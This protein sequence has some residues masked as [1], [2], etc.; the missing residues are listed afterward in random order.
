MIHS[1]YILGNF[2]HIEIVFDCIG[3]PGSPPAF[4]DDRYAKLAKL[5]QL[6]DS[7][8][9]TQEERSS[10]SRKPHRPY[11]VSARGPGAATTLL[12]MRQTTRAVLYSFLQLCDRGGDRG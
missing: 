11:G 2:P 7:G 5:K 4:G 6:L 8:A 1:P 12:A 10:L 9:I 3:K